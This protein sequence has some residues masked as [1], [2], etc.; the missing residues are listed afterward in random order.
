M[1][2]RRRIELDVDVKGLRRLAG[3]PRSRR[4]RAARALV[5]LGDDLKPWLAATPA[6]CPTG[7]RG[8]WA[9]LC[10]WTAVGVAS[11][12][13]H[14]IALVVRRQ[15]PGPEVLANRAVAGD[16]PSSSSFP[17]TH[18]SSAFGFA[19]AASVAMP[20]AVLGPLALVVAWT[21]PAGGRHYPSDVLAGAV[22]GAVAAA[23]VMFGQRQLP[24]I[25][26]NRH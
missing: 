1:S 18:T 16:Q 21:R 15:R 6:L 20:Q 9:A 22:T 3:P 7:R 8:C 26:S 24:R 19:T 12:L 25:L 5:P 4:A 13:A 17:S 10:G 11:G 2:E 23:A 14:G